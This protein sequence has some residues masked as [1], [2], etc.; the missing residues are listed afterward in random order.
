VAPS[1]LTPV[2]KTLS[3]LIMSCLPAGSEQVFSAT[4]LFFNEKCAVGSKEA[5][6]E[7]VLILDELF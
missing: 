7:F 3:N 4:A 2:A 5:F 1:A 6:L